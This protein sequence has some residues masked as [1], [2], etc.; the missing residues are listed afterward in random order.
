MNEFFVLFV[1]NKVYIVRVLDVWY[2]KFW[3]IL[4]L[5]CGFIKIW[6]VEYYF[7]KIRIVYI[8]LVI[9]IVD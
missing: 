7:W 3:Y 1:K 5:V 8:V 2:I 6:S 9:V 4:Y